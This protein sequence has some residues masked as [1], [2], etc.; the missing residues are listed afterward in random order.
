[1]VKVV[2]F[3]VVKV[4][5]GAFGGVEDY[6]AVEFK[7]FGFVGSGYEEAFV[8]ELLHAGAVAKVGFAQG[9]DFGKVVVELFTEGGGDGCVDDV[10][11]KKVDD[12]VP[13]VDWFDGAFGEK[14]EVEPLEFV[15]DGRQGTGRLRRR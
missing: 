11:G 4:G 15:D 14:V 9:V 5:I 1:M 2:V 6:D 10:M 3:Y 8:A 12:V 13:L 7:A